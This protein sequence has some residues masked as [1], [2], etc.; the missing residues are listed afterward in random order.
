[1][2]VWKRL[3]IA[4]GWQEGEPGGHQGRGMQPVEQGAAGC[5]AERLAAGTSLAAEAHGPHSSCQ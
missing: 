2:R 1:M 3:S 5:E 4:K